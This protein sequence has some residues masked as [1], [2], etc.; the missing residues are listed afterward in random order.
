MNIYRFEYMLD[1]V[2]KLQ[3][4]ER[5]SLLQRQNK[6]NIN[7]IS[8]MREEQLMKVASFTEPDRLAVSY[9]LKLFKEKR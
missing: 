7:I 1:L 9:S 3:S 5:L 2:S 4:K 6:A 8:S